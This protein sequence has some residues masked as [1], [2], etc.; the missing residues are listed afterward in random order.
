MGKA[1]RAEVAKWDWRAATLHLLNTQYP[2]AIARFR[3]QQNKQHTTSQNIYPA[4]A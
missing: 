4:V 3:E 1:A 2:G